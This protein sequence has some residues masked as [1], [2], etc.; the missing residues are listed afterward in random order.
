MPE[1]IYGKLLDRIEKLFEPLERE[2]GDIKRHLDTIVKDYRQLHVDLEIL[3]SNK[4]L[5]FHD[6][7][8]E[9]IKERAEKLE[10]E[11][12][13]LELITNE[14]KSD[15]LIQGKNWTRVVDTIFKVIIAGIGTYILYILGIKE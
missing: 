2:I 6:L 1:E 13:R 3:K 14:V 10:Q 12:H 11:I 8:I 15:T 5:S 9:E 7:Q 4:T